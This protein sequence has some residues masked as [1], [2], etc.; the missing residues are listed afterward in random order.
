VE[1]SPSNFAIIDRLAGHAQFG[2]SVGRG[3]KKPLSP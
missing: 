1:I 2:G 3:R